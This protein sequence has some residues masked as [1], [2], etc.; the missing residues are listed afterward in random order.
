MQL[1]FGALAECALVLF[2]IN[3]ANFDAWHGLS[4]AHEFERRLVIRLRRN[5]TAVRFESGTLDSI[6]FE[7]R[8][9]RRRGNAEARLREPIHGH[10]RFAMK[11]VT[12]EAR[13][14]SF[15]RGRGHRL[16]AVG[17]S[18]P[19]AEIEAFDI[20][21]RHFSH[22]Q[23]VGEIRRGTDG[24]AVIVNRPKPAVGLA[25]ER[26]RRHHD[27]GNARDNRHEPGAN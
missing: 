10:Q 17:C 16:R 19:R 15:E 20:L 22:A 24:S 18:A 4:G 14:K 7:A 25:E 21:V 13:D 27:Q 8:A 9:Q 6:H 23:L 5:R 12:S 26:E 1:A 3:D 11:A 2:F